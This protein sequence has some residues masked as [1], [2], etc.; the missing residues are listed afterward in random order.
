MS[1]HCLSYALVALTLLAS[2]NAA[3]LNSNTSNLDEPS[4]DAFCSNAVDLYANSNTIKTYTIP[5]VVQPIN[6]SADPSTAAFTS[7]SNQVWQVKS[8]IG[9][10]P[11]S[12]DTNTESLLQTSI[13]L[14]T[15]N[16]GPLPI[17]Q[18]LSTCNLIFN[19]PTGDGGKAS[20]DGD[21]SS[22]VGKA[23]VDDIQTHIR[24]LSLSIASSPNMTLEQACNSLSQSLFNL[25]KSCPKGTSDGK[26]SLFDGQG[27]YSNSKSQAA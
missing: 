26:L 19:M 5:A 25:P 15:K 14:D 2:T 3:T 1:L 12:N 23:C 21:C 13:Y 27:L 7:D 10:S 4:N 22:L 24:D 6:D 9:N 11:G 18:A 8:I 20:S 16:D 17:P